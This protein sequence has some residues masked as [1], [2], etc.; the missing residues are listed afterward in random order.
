MNSLSHSFHP[1]RVMLLSRSLHCLQHLLLPIVPG[2]RWVSSVNGWLP[3]NFLKGKKLLALSLEGP[4]VAGAL[5]LQD[6]S[7]ES[8]FSASLVALR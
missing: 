2:V 8:S 3:F 7:I 1:I 6:N 4:S 5:G